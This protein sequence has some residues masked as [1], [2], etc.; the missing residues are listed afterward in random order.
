VILDLLSSYKN[1]GIERN[2]HRKMVSEVYDLIPY[3]YICGYYETECH[4][5]SSS[6]RISCRSWRLCRVYATVCYSYSWWENVH[7]YYHLVLVESVS[8]IG[9]NTKELPSYYKERK[10]ITVVIVWTISF[11][12]SDRRKISAFT[13]RDYCTKYSEYQV[14]ASIGPIVVH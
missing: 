14:Q 6:S 11:Y 10:G 13:V 8:S 3:I 12:T 4:L 7:F 9:S 1:N 2:S 5:W